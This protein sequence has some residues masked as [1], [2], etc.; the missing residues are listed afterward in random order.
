MTNEHS[1]AEEDIFFLFCFHSDDYIEL[2]LSKE[3]ERP[4][5]GW[6]VFPLQKPCKVCLLEFYKNCKKW[7]LKSFYSLYQKHMSSEAGSEGA[8][9]YNTS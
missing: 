4:N 9:K 1:H 8:F 3:Q 2:N 7:I 6:E 5:K